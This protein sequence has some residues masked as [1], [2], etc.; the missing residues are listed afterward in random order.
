[1]KPI[2][3]LT[4]SCI[5]LFLLAALIFTNC[6]KESDFSVLKGPYLGQKPPGMAVELFAPG[7]FS[8]DANANIFNSTTVPHA[9]I[10]GDIGLD[11]I[12]RDRDDVDFYCFTILA[13]LCLPQNPE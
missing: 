7:F 10:D 11:T 1:M 2:V 6:A 8:T 4:I 13:A 5:N 3:K 12:P 9:T